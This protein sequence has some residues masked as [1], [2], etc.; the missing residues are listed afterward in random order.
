MFS[1]DA[2][3]DMSI[4][5]FMSSSFSYP[6]SPANANPDSGGLFISKKKVTH[7]LTLLHNTLGF[8]YAYFRCFSVHLP[9]F[10]TFESIF[11]AHV[12]YY[13]YFSAK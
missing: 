5:S 12:K 7:F 11:N 3:E 6:C 8:Q 4:L 10:S 9:L 1:T 13:I 2:K